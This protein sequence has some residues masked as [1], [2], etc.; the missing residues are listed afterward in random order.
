MIFISG[1]RPQISCFLRHFLRLE[2]LSDILCPF[3]SGRCDAVALLR[4][5]EADGTDLV[6]IEQILVFFKMQ[7]RLVEQSGFHKPAAQLLAVFCIVVSYYISLVNIIYPFRAY[8]FINY[9]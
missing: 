7:R 8:R 4:E 6:R 1:Q 2:K 3:H 9:L 5:S